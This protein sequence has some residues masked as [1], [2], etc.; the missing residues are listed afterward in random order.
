MTVYK[1]KDGEEFLEIFQDDLDPPSPL[2][3]D[4]LG[5]I[6][7]WHKRY[8]LGDEQ[9]KE[10]PTEF[11]K[12]LPV[13]TI[14]LPIY[15]YDHS[16]LTLSTSPFNC[17]WDSGQLGFIY[18]TPDNIEKLGVSL[19]NVEAQLQNEVAIYN[20]YVQGNVYGYS[21][22]KI[23]TCPNCSHEEKKIIDSCC[24]FYGHDHEK[25]GLLD[26]AGI[27]NWD[28]WEEQ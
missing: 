11:L 26:N 28:E 23:V 3:W 24:G 6:A 18:A 25:S 27:T 10:D 14:H 1:H 21:R 15:M 12:N 16:G 13:G 19:E 20:D 2:E 9:P 22:F 5:V 7:T 4:N 8:N 17:P